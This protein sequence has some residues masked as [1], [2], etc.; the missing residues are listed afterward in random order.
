MTFAA[1]VLFGV[2]PLVSFIYELL[3]PGLMSPYVTSS[4]VTGAA[5]FAVGAIK[6]RFVEQKWYRA[7][8]ETVIVG[9]TG[10]VLAYLVGIVLKNFVS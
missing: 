6:G 5:F 3:T 7:G 8:I 2:L 9:G 4:L 1:F 10:A